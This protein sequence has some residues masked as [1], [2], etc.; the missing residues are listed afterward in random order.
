M[1]HISG[2]ARKAQRFRLWTTQP[3]TTKSKAWNCETVPIADPVWT[4][5]RI[6]VA[7]EELKL[8]YYTGETL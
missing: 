2:L 5:K 8:R 4:C 1:A 7:V 3:E 6:C